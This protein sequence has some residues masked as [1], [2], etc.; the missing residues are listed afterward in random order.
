MFI[1]MAVFLFNNVSAKT[2]TSVNNFTPK[3]PF[4]LLDYSRDIR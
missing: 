1:K 3:T 2:V 4:C